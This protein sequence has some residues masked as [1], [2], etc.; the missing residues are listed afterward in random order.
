MH[1]V[2]IWVAGQD[3][4]SAKGGLLAYC[5][6][7]RAYAGWQF[8]RRGHGNEMYSVDSVASCP[9]IAS[10]QSQLT[11]TKQQKA[12]TLPTS[13]FFLLPSSSSLEPLSRSANIPAK[14]ILISDACSVLYSRPRSLSIVSK[15]SSSFFSTLYPSGG[16]HIR[17]NPSNL[18][19]H[20][21][22]V[23]NAFRYLRRCS[24]RPLPG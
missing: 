17:H 3:G 12:V 16:L 14:E 2:Y 24:C 9:F 1:S 5:G 15:P 10:N 21:T 19:S 11:T 18:I 4:R 20:T 13:S 23:N 6:S 8:G 7:G 22:L